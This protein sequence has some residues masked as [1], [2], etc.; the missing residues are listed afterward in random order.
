MS[1]RRRLAR[2]RLEI[3]L[4]H[5]IPAYRRLILITDLLLLMYA[6]ALMFIHPVAGSVIF[7]PA[8]F[9]LIMSN[10]FTI[11]L[12]TARFGAWLATFWGRYD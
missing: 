10:S 2:E 3:Y 6:A 8:I 1:N 9:L 4:V 5:L 11:V 7:I 12:Y